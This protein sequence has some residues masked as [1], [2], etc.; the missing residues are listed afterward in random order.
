MKKSER[1]DV[2]TFKFE[3]SKKDNSQELEKKFE[4]TFAI[5]ITY[6]KKN[7][8]GIN[9]NSRK[10]IETSKEKFSNLVEEGEEIKN[11][12]KQI[13][14]PLGNEEEKD[15]NS[16]DYKKSEEKLGIG[17]QNPS[18]SNF[19]TSL[20]IGGGVLLAIIGLGTLLLVA[21]KKKKIQ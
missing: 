1:R 13:C 18:N 7:N 4:R 2:S 9:V 14:Y 5:N 12:P 19:P 17:Q 20:I 21:K 6:Q 11:L 8:Q 10:L 16:S 15:K 3:N